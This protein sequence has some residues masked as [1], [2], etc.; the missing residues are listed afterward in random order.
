MATRTRYGTGS[1]VMAIFGVIAF[2]IILGVLLVLVRAN[3]NNPLVDL[4][5][6]IG[7]FF[8]RPFRGL[9][10]QDTAREEVLVNWTI[11]A[12][13]YLAVGALI[14]GFIRRF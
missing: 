7:R 10:A 4:T 5:L 13:A 9:I 12:I 3:P 1:V 2:I 11:A 6:D 8:A 14:S